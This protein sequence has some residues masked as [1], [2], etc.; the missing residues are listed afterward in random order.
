MIS[1]SGSSLFCQQTPIAFLICPFS[2]LAN[3]ASEVAGI[4]SSVPGAITNK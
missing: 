2:T 1:I 4:I 3:Q